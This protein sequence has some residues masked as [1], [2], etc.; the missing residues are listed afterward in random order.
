MPTHSPRARALTS[1]LT[2]ALAA[3]A[4]VLAAPAARAQ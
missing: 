4:V 1:V 2:R 3:T